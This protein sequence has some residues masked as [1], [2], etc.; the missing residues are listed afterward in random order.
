MNDLRQNETK[1]EPAKK[2]LKEKQIQLLMLLAAALAVIISAV[3]VFLPHS[4]TTSTAGGGSGGL[5]G[6]RKDQNDPYYLTYP[7]ENYDSFTVFVDAG[8]GYDDP[9]AFTDYLDGLYESDI[10]LDM[11]LRLRDKLSARGINVIMSRTENVKPDGHENEKYV[12]SPIDRAELVNNSDTTINL[13]ISLHCNSFPSDESVKG[14]RLYFYAGSD[15]YTC[16]LARDEADG[17][18]SVLKDNTPRLFSMKYD[19]AYYIL[20]NTSLPA[21]LVECGFVTNP[22]DAALMLNEKWKDDFTTGLAEG[23]FKFFNMTD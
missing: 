22:D 1:T 9:G 7:S 23:V 10:N 2:P 5:S 15:T 6:G 4:G 8:H 20:K 14:T 3:A 18:T 16:A 11:A 17:I 12:L 19:D 21:V 13:M